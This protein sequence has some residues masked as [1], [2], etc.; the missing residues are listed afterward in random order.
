MDPT[1]AAWWEDLRQMFYTYGEILAGRDDSTVPFNALVV[2][3]FSTHYFGHDESETTGERLL[4]KM[5][6]PADSMSDRLLADV[7]DGVRR[8]GNFPMD[9]E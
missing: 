1:R 5:N 4:L 6:R 9:V 2:S 7:W 8:Y 3:N